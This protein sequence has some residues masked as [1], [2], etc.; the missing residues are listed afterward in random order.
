MENIASDQINVDSLR[1]IH[2]ENRM[3]ET[4][5]KA[6]KSNNIDSNIKVGSRLF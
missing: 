4:P 1:I 5:D 6:T 2:D 3:A